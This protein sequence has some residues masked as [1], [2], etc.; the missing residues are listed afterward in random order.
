MIPCRGR[1]KSSDIGELLLELESLLGK[2]NS[3]TQLLSGVHVLLEYTWRDCREG[4]RE[5]GAIL[6]RLDS[7]PKVLQKV[8]KN[9]SAAILSFLK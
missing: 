7:S 5:G 3:L 9:I 1:K 6:K 8:M 4:R 2:A